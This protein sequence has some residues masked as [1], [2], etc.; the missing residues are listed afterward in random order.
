MATPTCWLATSCPNGPL[1]VQ[2]ASTVGSEDVEV[3]VVSGGIVA[4]ACRET[5]ATALGFLAALACQVAAG[6]ADGLL[7]GA[8]TVGS[9]GGV[10]TTASGGGA[11]ITPVTTAELACLAGTS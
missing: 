3:G 9:E 8:S 11:A 5:I 1:R 10:G 2:G 7:L 6:G 4:A